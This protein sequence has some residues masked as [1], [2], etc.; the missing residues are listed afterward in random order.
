M[1]LPPTTN[2]PIFN[3]SFYL[4]SNDYLTI[5]VGDKRYQKLGG[6]G[7]FSSL[8]VAGSLACGSLTIAGSVVDLS[9]LS[10]VTAGT[11]VASKLVMVDANK[12]VSSFRNLTAT[13]FYGTIQTSDQ[14]NITSVGTLSSLT[15]SGS[16][17]GTLSTTDQPYITSLETLSPL[18]V[19]GSISGTL[20]TAAQPNITSLGTLPSLTVSGS[21]TGT[22]STA[23]QPNITSLGT[24][25]TLTVSGSIAG[26]LSTA[27]QPNITSVGTL[28]SLSLSGASS[29]GA[30]DL[31]TTTANDLYFGANNTRR[32]AINQVAMSASITSPSYQLDVSG[33]FSSTSFYMN[34]TLVTTTASDLN[35]I[36]GYGTYL[37]GIMPGT[38]SASKAMVTNS[39]SVIQF[40]S[41]S[42][43]TNQMTFFANTSLR[44]SIRVYRVDD[45]GPLTIGTQIDGSAST[46]RT[47]PILNLVSSIDPTAQVGGVSAT[48]ADLFNI[49]WNDKPSVGFTSQTHRFCFN[50]GNSQP[51]KTGYPHTFALATSADAICLNPTG[52]T[53]T[54]SSGGCLYLVN[55]TTPKL[56]F[57]TNTPYSSSLGTAP[58]TLQQGNMYIRCTNAFN[59]GSTAFDTAAL[60]ESSNV[61]APIA[62]AFQLSNGSS[63]T[64]TNSAY[65][66]TVS[67]N[68]FVIMTNNS[69]KVTLTAAGRLDIG[70]SAP[71]AQLDVSGS[72]S[73]I[74]C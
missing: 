24:L 68:D 22:L 10:G 62:F 5:A 36:S 32:L 6:I 51:Y 57:N 30:C 43:T 31:R 21:I 60:F 37:S 65:M 26:T 49:N 18:N 3:S 47:Y 67:N 16:I 53:A 9:S 42:A 15:V 50:V 23:A 52:S 48:S 8:A 61:G 71:S 40:R 73:S 34:G 63:G 27:A 38:V 44:D 14:P 28:S 41:G 25:S 72:V 1:S 13:N 55:D 12:D 2:S 17:T 39:N 46:N 54:P 59:D 35:G 74:Y 56:L 20:S 58:I 11:I 19:S 70:L 69:R 45:S 64:S 66:G 4:G 33:S 7:V 29:G